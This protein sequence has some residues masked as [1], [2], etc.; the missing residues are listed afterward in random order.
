MKILKVI[1]INILIIFTLL[2]MLEISFRIYNKIVG[3]SISD[4]YVIDDEK[5]G[6]IHNKTYREKQLKNKCGE[7]LLMKTPE[8]RLIIKFPKYDHTRRTVLFIGDSYTH[9]HEVS[10]GAA[11]YDTF[12]QLG[13]G[14]YKVYTAAVG[15]FGTLQQYLMLKEVYDDIKPDYIIWQ[16]CSNDI[17]NNVFEL[18]N[19][20]FFNNQRPRPYYNLK[21][22]EIEMKNPGFWLFDLSQ[23]FRFV[24]PKIVAFDHKYKLGLMKFMN[25]FIELDAKSRENYEKTGFEITEALI[26]KVIQE[27]QTSTLIGFSVN[28]PLDEEF[29]DIFVKNGAHYW[30][31]FAKF[32]DGHKNYNC[33]PYDAHWNH[34]GNVV[35]GKKIFEL[36]EDFIGEE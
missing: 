11:Y 26:K 7:D 33:V 9:A 17:E 22:G 27:Y 29:R 18:D 1:S 5:Y 14:K 20:S 32:M 24:F 30:E 4:G 21:T 36:F 31:G 3:K 6:W 8:H 13:N 2:F 25:S 19:S 15:G 16:M 10:T 28:E 34:Y 23:G 12:E 35:A